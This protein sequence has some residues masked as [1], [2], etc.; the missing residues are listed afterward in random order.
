MSWSGYIPGSVLRQMM[1]D[2]KGEQAMATMTADT[3]DRVEVTLKGKFGKDLYGSTWVEDEKGR[4][5]YYNAEAAGIETK[6]IAKHV[7]QP[8]LN[9]TVVRL[10]LTGD[11]YIKIGHDKWRYVNLSSTPSTTIHTWSEILEMASG[12][13]LQV[14]VWRN[15]DVKP[16]ESMFDRRVYFERSGGNKTGAYVAYSDSALVID[17]L[18]GR[19]SKEEA[20]RFARSILTTY[21]VD[22]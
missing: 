20:L 1:L 13:V 4:K 5:V 10:P 16:G 18:T 6:V 14:G 3:N 8:T 2:E 11:R 12:T 15:S 9:G 7:P 22:A 21:G 19:F 17:G